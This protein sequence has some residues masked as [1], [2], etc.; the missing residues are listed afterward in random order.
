M[1]LFDIFGGGEEEDT[2][3]YDSGFSDNGQT[4]RVQQRTQ[5]NGRGYQL[6]TLAG[7]DLYNPSA[8]RKDQTGLERLAEQRG[9]FYY[10]G[11]ATGAQDAIGTART[12]IAPYT[13]ALGNYGGAFMGEV[14]QGAGDM[15]T[16][17]GGLYDTAAALNQYAQQGPGPSVA[18]AQLQ[19][20]TNAALR[21][22]MMMAGAGRGAGGGAAAQRQAAMNQ[23][24]IQGQG[25]ANAAMLQA[26]EAQDWRQAQLQAMGAAGGMY[27]QGAGIGGQY[28]Q[29]MGGMATDAIKGAGALQAGTEGLAHDINMGS[30]TGSMGYEALLNQIYG[31]DK[32]VGVGN[33]DAAAREKAAELQFF[34]T[35]LAS[36]SDVRAKKNIRPA[37]AEVE[38]TLRELGV[39]QGEAAAEAGRQSQRQ[40]RSQAHQFALDTGL[41]TPIEYDAGSQ[42]YRPRELEAVSVPR[43]PLDER[44]ARAAEAYGQTHTGEGALADRRGRARVAFDMRPASASTFEYKD[45]AR[46][47]EGTYVGPMAQEL[48]HVPGVVNETPDGTKAIDTSRLSLFNTSALG[49]VQ[50]KQDDTDA[51]LIEIEGLLSADQDVAPVDLNQAPKQRGVES[52]LKAFGRQ[53]PS[54]EEIEGASEALRRKFGDASA[55]EFED[56]AYGYKRGRGGLTTPIATRKGRTIPSLT[57]NA[58][59]LYGP[60]VGNAPSQEEQDEIEREFYDPSE[61]YRTVRL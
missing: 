26:Q 9:N 28:A 42:I 49:D 12:N 46:H 45:P 27:G 33:A 58:G 8:V 1:G 43:G 3:F 36:I 60:P 31:T 32:G 21:Q 19:A 16:G 29:G 39:A 50:R 37:E 57:G 54:D 40:V 22:Q 18:Q 47:G 17:M 35:T 4:E 14:V 7:G 5:E 10:G 34:G 11:S 25:N 55:S 38:S 20:N 44:R 24:M 30:L 51:R 48:E 52:A 61:R 53:A 6:G 23:A 59:P 2:D 13:T 15:R 56:Y 41:G